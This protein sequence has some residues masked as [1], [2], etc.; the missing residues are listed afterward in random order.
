MS[1]GLFAAWQPRYAELGIATFPVRN[2]RPAVKG[3]LRAGLRASREFASKFPSDG[4]FGVA[5]RKNRLVVLDV[6]SPDERLLAD[7]MDEFGP[8]PFVV[9]SGSGNFQ[10]WYR[11]SGE[12][13][14]VRPDHRPIDILGDGFVVAPPSVGAKG[15]YTIIAGT[16]DDLASLPAMRAGNVEPDAGTASGRGTPF[17]GQIEVGRRNDD[18]FRVCMTLARTCGSISELMD[19]AIKHNHSAFSEPLPEDEVTRVVASAWDKE[20]AGEN[21][22]GRG[23]R[24]VFSVSEVDGL[25]NSEPDAFLL[26]TVLRR[27]HWRR[28]FV[29]ANAMAGIMPGGGWTRKRLAAARF[30]LLRTGEISLVRPASRGSPALYK[31]KGGQ[32]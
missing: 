21:W 19:T 3:Y 15:T 23:G 1:P 8:T 28:P 13:R 20:L 24:V 14:S 12:R 22:F 25:L 31:F 10:A 2:K 29:V 18:L 6:D 11:H 9:Q 26:L 27:H 16:L 30:Y 7:A 4:A 5:C 17:F 32:K